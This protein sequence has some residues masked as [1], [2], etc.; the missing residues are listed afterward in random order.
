MSS[1]GV[2][3]IVWGVLLFVLGSIGL[4]YFDPNAFGDGPGFV[5]W[6]V[7]LLGVL[8]FMAGIIQ[9]IASRLA[10]LDDNEVGGYPAPP[11]QPGRIGT[12]PPVGATT[13]TSAPPTATAT[14]TVR[15]VKPPPVLVE[16]NELALRA[17]VAMA[18][19]DGPLD[20]AEIDTIGRIYREVATGDMTRAG[21]Q[22][23]ASGMGRGSG[24][25]D[26]L[27]RSERH[28]SIAA[29]TIILKA[30]YLILAVDGDM[31]GEEETRIGDIVEALRLPYEQ[32]MAAIRDAHAR[33]TVLGGQQA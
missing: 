13:G 6:A 24:I 27:A 14:A 17:M 28:L 2:S 9:W 7:M 26:E 8:L 18:L 31:R 10:G 20:D 23:V 11:A 22:A 15:P 1:P 4:V 19:A 25:Y 16:P 21:I 33:A 5:A 29:K 32:A 12:P 30:A 3:K